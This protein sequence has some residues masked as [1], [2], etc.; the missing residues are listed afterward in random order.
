MFSELMMIKSGHQ[1]NSFGS[2]KRTS[3]VIILQY[4]T[5]VTWVL[6]LEGT[7][8]KAF[9]LQNGWVASI[10]FCTSWVNLVGGAELRIVWWCS[11]ILVVPCVEMWWF[12]PSNFH[13]LFPPLSPRR[14]DLFV[15]FGHVS[16]NY[17]CI[18]SAQEVVGVPFGD[19]MRKWLMN[20]TFV[21]LW[22]IVHYYAGLSTG[23]CSLSSR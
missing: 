3:F 6:V 7:Q 22:A 18:N 17:S 19:S 13:I 23:F 10:S 1:R 20:H 4:N 15:F 16:S 11:P 12:E 5:C 9:G 21:D 2:P 14:L 8:S